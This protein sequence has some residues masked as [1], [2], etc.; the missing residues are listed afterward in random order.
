VA[1]STVPAQSRRTPSAPAWIRTPGRADRRTRPHRGPLRRTRPPGRRA[2]LSR[3][4]LRKAVLRKAAL[5]RAA[6]NRAALSRAALRKE[7]ALSRAAHSRA[8]H[9]RAAIRRAALRR[10][11]LR[12]A[13]RGT[14]LSARRRRRPART[15]LL[16][17]PEFK[18]PVRR[19]RPLVPSPRARSL[20]GSQFPGRSRPR[21]SR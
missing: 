18:H 21:R 3:A 17:M 8:A 12:K 14:R 7:A 13:V 15:P 9:S 11:A 19:R 10:P 1:P 5:N 4:A 20:A 2:A 16:P 6:L